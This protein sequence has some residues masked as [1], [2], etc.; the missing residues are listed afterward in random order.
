M[1]YE[2]WHET[3][4]NEVQ[5]YDDFLCNETSETRLNIYRGA[6]TCSIVSSAKILGMYISADVKWNTHITHTVSKASKHLYFLRL[7]KRSGI[8]RALLLTVF[9][10]C[11]RPILEYGCQVWSYGITVPFR[12]D[13]TY[14]KTSLKNN[15]SRTIL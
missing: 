11:I 13:R 4:W 2:K 7:L 1:V 14:S 10:T 5:R 8:D 15:P 12:W 6:W 3:Q 9:T